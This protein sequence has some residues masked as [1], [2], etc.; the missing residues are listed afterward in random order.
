M[1]VLYVQRGDK[2]LCLIQYLSKVV[3]NSTHEVIRYDSWV[4]L[5]DRNLP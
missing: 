5:V 1:Y 2:M 4:I 3:G